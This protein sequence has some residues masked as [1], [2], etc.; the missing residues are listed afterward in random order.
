M[1]RRLYILQRA[2]AAIMAPL[3]LVHLAVIFYALGEGLSAA[4]IL[5]RT[6]G[7]FAWA[8]F[9]DLFVAAAAIHAPIGLR[10][11]LRDWTPWRGLGLDLALLAFGALLLILGLRAVAA[12]TLP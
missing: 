1:E 5:G 8:V 10:A 12:V 6:R 11:V 3:I 7:S 4:E 2:S 9:Y